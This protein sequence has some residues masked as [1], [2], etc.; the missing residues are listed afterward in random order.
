MIAYK[1][2]ILAH[3]FPPLP[4]IGAQRPYAFYKHFNKFGIYPTIVTRNWDADVSNANSNHA[5]SLNDKIILSDSEVGTVIRLPYSP[6]IKDKIICKY[7][8]SEYKYLR[9]FISFLEIFF[10]WSSR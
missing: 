5:A 8:N 1:A 10:K 2:L 3:D 9:K 6:S 4:S 7:G